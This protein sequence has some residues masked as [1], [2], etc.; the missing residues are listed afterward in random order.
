MT[1]YDISQKAGVSIA[2]VSRV[3]NG[4][5]KVSEATRR[6]VLSVMEEYSY[7]PNAFARGLGL[8]S[9]RTVGILC[10]DSSDIY[11][12]KAVYYMEQML[13]ELGYDSIL[14]CC[15]YEHENKVKYTNL[16]LSK[17]VDSIIFAGSYFVGDTE[18]DN[19]YIRETAAAVPVML[20]NAEYRCPGVYSCL[21]DDYSAMHNAVQRLVELGR[22]R[23]VYV[24]NTCSFSGKRKLAGYVD[25]VNARSL[26]PLT[27]FAERRYEVSDEIL[28]AAGALKRLYEDNPDIDA[29]LT[30]D[31]Q[32][33]LGAVKFARRAGLDIPRDIAII[34][35]NNSVLAISNEPELTSIDNRLE[36]LCRQLV[37]NLAD[38]LNGREV[39]SK[40]VFEAGLIE[41]GTT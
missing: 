24:Y 17:K 29:I 7:T 37:G 32:L 28:E 5:N 26:K 39:N 30:A 16:L 14:C 35:C 33:A 8:N 34:G 31:D 36:A 23:I 25:A 18:E 38:I 2:T 21:C 22:R 1:I 19:A 27:L 11:L 15:G 20:L 3:L 4:S 12:A 9:T 13:R 10:A 6:K 40:M 41:R